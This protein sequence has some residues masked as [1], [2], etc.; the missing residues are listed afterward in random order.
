MVQGVWM[1]LG[2]WVGGWVGERVGERVGE[3]FN[4]YKALFELEPFML[5]S[6]GAAPSTSSSAAVLGR[7]Q[8]QRRAGHVRATDQGVRGQHGMTLSAE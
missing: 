4:S 3:G 8:G 6:S 5:P 1:A 7:A 2:A